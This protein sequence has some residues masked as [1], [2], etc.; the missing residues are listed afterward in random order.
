MFQRRPCFQTLVKSQKGYAFTRTLRFKE[1]L[2]SE[3][4]AAEAKYA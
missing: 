4:I 2:Y 1:K 3:I